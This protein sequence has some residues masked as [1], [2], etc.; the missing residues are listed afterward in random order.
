MWKGKPPASDPCFRQ[1]G[2]W[3]AVVGHWQHTVS[4]QEYWGVQGGGTA[5]PNGKEAGDAVMEGAAPFVG[6]ILGML[7]ERAGISD[8]MKTLA[9]A[10]GLTPEQSSDCED[11]EY[12]REQM[13]I[14]AKDPKTGK[15]HPLD[16]KRGCLTKVFA[17]NFVSVLESI[18]VMLGNKLVDWVVQA[19]RTAFMGLKESLRASAGAVPF[20]GWILS[21]LIEIIWVVLM[22]V[23]LPM[24]LKGLV[25][26]KLPEWMKIKELAKHP[27]EKFVDHPILSVVLGIVLSLLD[28]AVT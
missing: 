12:R 25:V 10:A 28:A 3:G 24:L 19:L 13:K 11:P 21:G 14:P 23:G 16:N 20:V 17:K 6:K 8:M 4:Q 1:R 22:D 27:V 2:H 7:L 5:G 18:I 26:A 15:P 9:K